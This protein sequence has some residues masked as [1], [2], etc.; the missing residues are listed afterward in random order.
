M[1]DT[2]EGDILKISKLI[3][4]VKARAR[5]RGIPGVAGG[6]AM[7]SGELKARRPDRFW[8]S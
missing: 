6:T 5:G 4:E 2:L 8:P 7:L 3:A 1:G